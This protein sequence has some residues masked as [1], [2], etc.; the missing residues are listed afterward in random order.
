[1]LVIVTQDD[2]SDLED[3]WM[4]SDV[5]DDWA[6]LEDDD[7]VTED[8]DVATVMFERSLVSELSDAWEN[9][10][11]TDPASTSTGFSSFLT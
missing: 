11:T 10:L 9:L 8:S 4:I 3:V 2:V 6:K 1:M 5:S 7:W